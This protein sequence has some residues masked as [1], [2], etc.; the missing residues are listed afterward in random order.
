MI[1]NRH[2]QS[3][4]LTLEQQDNIYQLIDNLIEGLDDQA[5]SELLSGYEGDLSNLLSALFDESNKVLN[6][7][8][9]KIT[10]ASF[11]YLDHFTDA[12]EESF[13]VNSLT[14]FGQSVLPDFE[15]NWH[16]LEWGQ[17]VHIYML[18]CIIAARDHSKSFFFSKLYPL[19]KLYRYK[20]FDP[21]F[22]TSRERS[23]CEF[24]VLFSNEI[25]LGEEL[26]DFIKDEIESN[27]I[28]YDKLYPGKQS[29]GW[30]KQ[31]IRCKNGSRMLVK[32]AGSKAR[33]LH[34]G[35]IV[36][37]DY[38]NDQALYSATQRRKAINHFHSVIMNMIVPN[39]QV[40]TVGCVSGSTIVTTSDGLKRI[41][42]L[43]PIDNKIDKSITSFELSL[44]S[45][46]GEDVTSHFYVNG[47][48]IT[49]KIVTE[50]GFEL[51]CSEI[52]PLWRMSNG[53]V[54][55]VKSNDLRIHDYI[56]LKK[57]LNQ[58]GK[59]IQV[60][61]TKY[62]KLELGDGVLNE[63][64]L[65]TIGLWIAEGSFEENGRINITIGDEEVHEFLKSR[66]IAGV[67]FK[68]WGNNGLT[69]SIS[70]IQ[71]LSLL[72]EI[73]GN[74]ELKSGAI[75]KQIPQQILSS[76]RQSMIAFLQGLY[77]GD[78]CC[79]VKDDTLQINVASIS[80]Q[81]IQTIQQILLNFGIVGSI[82]EHHPQTS[83]LAIGKHK[84]YALTCSGIN[85]EMFLD[86]IGFR[87]KRKND[88]W[89]KNIK[90]DRTLVVGLRSIWKQMRKECLNKIKIPST[91][92]ATFNRDVVTKNRLRNIIRYFD[93]KNFNSSTL[94]L[95]REKS[96]DQLL[97]VKIESITK[98]KNYTFDFVI[99][100]SHSFIGNGFINHNTPFHREDLYGDLKKKEGWR[101]FEYPAIF[102]DGSLLWENR[103][104]MEK[105]LAKRKS[106]GALIFSREILVKPVTDD[107]AIF[108][109][110]I[111]DK[112]YEGMQDYKLVPNI[113][114]FPRNINF[115]R[116]VT[117]CDFARSASVGADF[118][119]FITLGIDQQDRMWVLNVFREKGMSYNQQILNIKRIYANFRPDIIYM[120]D[121]QMQSLFVDGAKELGLPVEG[122]T[123]GTNKKNLYEGLP[124][125]AVLMEQG[126]I[127]FPI[128]DAKSKATMEQIAS[129]LASIAFIEDT[130]KLESTD[131]H[132]DSAMALWIACRA[133]HNA[134]TGFNFS[135]L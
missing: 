82:T 11:G 85:A 117:G 26:L 28:L 121:N 5:M 104:N 66:K 97:W 103:H 38:L 7:Q 25:S 16:H 48:T 60:D 131:Q 64:L 50:C 129:E 126:K 8:Q 6:F 111:L 123:T 127:K 15:M 52:H 17:M 83:Y 130:G 133:A 92:S 69:Y 96:N 68:Q 61:P 46:D 30:A 22:D 106:Q 42:D 100:K 115:K 10:T 79:Y 62:N 24:G 74:V 122:H 90:T 114:S 107:S 3:D 71:F 21:M 13:R 35:W 45:K 40:I 93:N 125:L 95:L 1:Q 89:S 81:L 27:E 75:N 120:E 59:K 2:L 84:K 36:V 124:A 87:L 80:K 70:S 33:G 88:K 4:A 72:K 109:K 39:G 9:G 20:K 57:G 135:F 18:L 94:E 128:G 34:P 98:S 102:P 19:W 119:C 44:E 108:T 113:H 14:Y 86:Q 43:C 51:E 65:Y 67:E 112:A 58:W 134:N 12:V 55:W 23:L 73:H 54:D 29:G 53:E 56:A 132:D 41:E 77:D 37:D 49:N 47:E 76:D 78:G 91:F 105:L 99:P 110:A 63:D 32:S 118:S 101:V 31:S 116:V